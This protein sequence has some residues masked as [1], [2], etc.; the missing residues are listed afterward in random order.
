MD[1]ATEKKEADGLRQVE[2]IREIEEPRT[3]AFVRVYSSEDARNG[4][5]RFCFFIPQELGDRFLKGVGWDFWPD[6]FAP[7]VE[8]TKSRK[9]GASLR[10]T[11]YLPRGN[12]WGAEALV[13]VRNFWGSRPSTIEIAEEF[14]L[15]YNLY[16]DTVGAVFLHVDRQGQEHEVVRCVPERVEVHLKFL[17]DFLRA[18]QMHLAMQWEG[19]YW[20]KYSL[21]ALGLE[22]GVTGNQSGTFRW[23]LA[24]ANNSLPEG[25]KSASRLLGKALLS[26]PGELE[27]RD[28]YAESAAAYPSFIV[29]HDERGSP[30]EDTCDPGEIGRD[31]QRGLSLVFFRRGVLAKYF[32]QPDKFC[33]E[34][35]RLSCGGLWGLRMDNDHPK[36]VIAFLKDLGQGLPGIER[37]HWRNYNVAPDG[38][39]SQTFY[40]RNVRGFFASPQMPDLRLKSLYPRVNELWAQHFGWPLWREPAAGDQY[41]FPQ[42]HVCLEENQAEFDQQ[43]ALLAKLLND[44][45]NEEKIAA[46]VKEQRPP[47]GGLNRLEKF[48]LESSYTD[49]SREIGPLR[50]VQ[51]LRSKGSAHRKGEDY[52]ACLKRAGIDRVPITEC[53]SR[54]FRGAVSFIDWIRKDVLRDQNI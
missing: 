6:D 42:L 34:D 17:V 43:I 37:A 39:P 19:H 2:R 46:A 13:R 25:H 50:L 4:F 41:V 22:P 11:Y 38:A 5:Q 47:V 21:E 35:G 30:V 3:A 7:H 31:A 36:Y 44:F 8:S 49:A 26:C 24:A 33:V 9:D 12:E 10:N 14:R 20:S 18:K 52:I 54:L 32:A 48:L 51:Q 27:Y 16:H 45:L 23:E 40:T 1:D 29:G 28:L 53:A 15:F